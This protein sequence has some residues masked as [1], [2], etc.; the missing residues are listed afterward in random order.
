MKKREVFTV[1]EKRLKEILS[2]TKSRL[3]MGF[4]S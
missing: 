2:M 3:Q 1:D 4:L